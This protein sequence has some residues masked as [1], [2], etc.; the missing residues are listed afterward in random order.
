M[1]TGK[2]T[3]EPFRAIFCSYSHKDERIA[4]RVESTCRALRN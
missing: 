1:R 3:Q 4:R 2:S